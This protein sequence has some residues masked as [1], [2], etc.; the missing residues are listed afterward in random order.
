MFN[1]EKM[2]L[3]VISA[4]NWLKNMQNVTDKHKIPYFQIVKRRLYKTDVKLVSLD[5]NY[6]EKAMAFKRLAERCELSHE[7][8]GAK[9]GESRV[10]IN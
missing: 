3:L 2:H 4:K 10:T 9:V 7:Q 8:I 1:F 5:L 6:I